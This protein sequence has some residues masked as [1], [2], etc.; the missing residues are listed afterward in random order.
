[1]FLR[2]GAHNPNNITSPKPYSVAS[3]CFL[4]IL[5]SS[6]IA[7]VVWQHLKASDDESMGSYT[8]QTVSKYI[9]IQKCHR[10]YFMVPKMLLEQ[11]TFNPNNENYFVK[12]I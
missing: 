11:E 10:I 4:G 1:M 5:F 6:V 12:T 2:Q 9:W 8:I 7:W 3:R